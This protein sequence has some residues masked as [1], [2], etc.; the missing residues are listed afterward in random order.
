[1]NKTGGLSK[2]LALVGCIL[3]WLPII[4][5]LI[6]GL[7]SSASGDIFRVDYLMPAELFIMVLIGGCFLVWASIRAHAMIKV[8]AWGLGVAVLMLAAGMVIAQLSGLASGAIEPNGLWWG[9]VVASL[10]IY[11]L[12]IITMG[13]GG[14]L[15]IKE[16]FQKRATA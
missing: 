12:G 5:P 11:I 7:L 8:V 3:V 13:V 14:I 9:V 4:L 10:I 6:F 15:L 2:S 16:L 1:M